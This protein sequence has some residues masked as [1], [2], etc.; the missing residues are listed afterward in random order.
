[1]TKNRIIWG[2]PAAGS[3]SIIGLNFQKS[4]L[5]GRVVRSSLSKALSQNVPSKSVPVCDC[6][7]AVE[8]LVKLG[9]GFPDQ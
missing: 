3:N 1:M 9:G 4:I 7:F 6:G 5:R 8:A 2:F